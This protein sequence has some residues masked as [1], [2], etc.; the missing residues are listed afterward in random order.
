METLEFLTAPIKTGE[1]IKDFVCDIIENP[2]EKPD[3]ILDLICLYREYIKVTGSEHCALLA[4]NGNDVHYWFF[5]I[6]TLKLPLFQVSLID[7]NL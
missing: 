4:T 1:D 3:V 7:K 6:R 5:D 2:M